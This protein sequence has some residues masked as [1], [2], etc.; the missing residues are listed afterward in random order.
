MTNLSTIILAIENSNPSSELGPEARPGVALG[1]LNSGGALAL[2]DEEPLRPAGPHDDDLMAAI[3]R[4]AQRAGISP[5]QIGRIAVSVGPGGYTALRIAIA[6]AKMI[7]EATGAETVAVPAADVAA[8]L[9]S[10]DVA[11]AAFAIALASKKE[12][13]FVTVFDS[14]GRSKTPGRV[15]SS[16][17]LAEVFAADRSIHRLF[18]DRFIP[19]SF[20][21]I[22]SESGVVLAPI[23]LN[24]VGCLEASLAISAVSPLD[25]APIYAREPE[26]VTLWRTRKS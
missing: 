21:R 1:R 18:A 26:A 10:P 12:S 14:A 6:T 23:R 19:D 20:H 8:R 3:D 11:G 4:L 24:A 13:A 9:V 17:D 25:L 2:L 7:A 22:L 16:M 15:M 5:S